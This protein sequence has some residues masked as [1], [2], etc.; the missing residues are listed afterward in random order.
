M[1]TY[2]SVFHFHVFKGTKA[3]V[4][5]KEFCSWF[6]GTAWVH[7]AH[8]HYEAESSGKGTVRVGVW[9][10]II[11]KS[12]VWEQAAKESGLYF[13]ETFQA[14]VYNM[15]NNRL[16]QCRLAGD[17][18]HCKDT[19]IKDTTTLQFALLTPIITNR[20]SGNVSWCCYCIFGMPKHVSL[21]QSLAYH[22]LILTSRFAVVLAYYC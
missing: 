15:R 19:N 11:A 2:A 17:L 16:E 14:A 21:S 4:V 7:M 5:A 12:F 18:C 9:P 22:A 1:L 8:V 10:A 6:Q 20:S 3:R 13:N